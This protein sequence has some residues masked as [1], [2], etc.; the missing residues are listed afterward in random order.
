MWFPTSETH[1]P[2]PNSSLRRA[3]NRTHNMYW[4]SRLLVSAVTTTPNCVS[5]IQPAPLLLAVPLV[6]VAASWILSTSHHLFLASIATAILA[7]HSQSQPARWP[8]PSLHPRSINHSNHDTA[9]TPSHLQASLFSSPEGSN[10]QM[11]QMWRQ[12]IQQRFCCEGCTTGAHG[13][14]PTTRWFGLMISLILTSFCDSSRCNDNTCMTATPKLSPS[15][16]PLSPSRF[17][18]VRAC[19][20][21]TQSL[22]YNKA[23]WIDDLVNTDIFL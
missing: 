12:A 18:A 2:L 1:P 21:C 19:N 4:S 7:S 11:Q 17:F 15:L 8:Q 22:C 13:L 23:V 6:V 3:R 10:S 14:F 20:R 5:L 9:C 16:R